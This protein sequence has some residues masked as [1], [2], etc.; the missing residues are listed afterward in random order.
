MT[1]RIVVKGALETETLS[2]DDQAFYYNKS[3]AFGLGNQHRHA[4]Q[5]IDAIVRSIA[6]PAQP[7]LS[8][9]V[10]TKIYSI[11]YK[12]ND[13]AHRA[14]IDHVVRHAAQTKEAR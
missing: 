2:A 6:N 7:V 11:R 13:A 5:E 4:W 10:G 12:P 8:I 1:L 14:F 9:Q 3:A